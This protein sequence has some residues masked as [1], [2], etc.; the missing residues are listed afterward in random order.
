MT[1][2]VRFAPSPTGHLHVGNAR[3]AVVNWVLARK[4]GG[5]A[6]LRLDDTDAQR[7]TAAFADAILA[8]LAWLGLTWD[9]VERQSERIAMYDAAAEKLRHSGRLYACYETP[10]ELAYARNRQHRMGLPPIYDR[11]ALSLSDEQRATHEADGRTPHWRFRLADQD[12]GFVDLVRG[13]TSF[14][15]RNLSDPVLIRSDG[16]YLYMLPS[17]VDDAD[18]AIT[19]VI[20]GEDHVTNSAI[21]TQLFEALGAP[22][23]M[24]AHL[25]LLTDTVGGKL[26]K[27][28]GSTNLDHFRE[29]GCE[30]MAINAMLATLGTAD[31]IEPFADLDAIVAAFEITRFGRAQPRFDEARLRAINARW[32]RERPYGDVA[33]RFEALGLIGANEPF[34]NAVRGNIERFSDVTL[35]H[36]VCFGEISPQGGDPGFLAVAADLLPDGP[37]SE[38]TWAPWTSAIREA[39][40]TKG[41]ALFKP[42]RRALTGREHGPEL[43]RLLPLMGRERVLG[44]LTGRE[45]GASS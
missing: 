3:I 28:F 44:R 6:V 27:R 12:I 41:K 19:H 36:E 39:T 38:S 23:P 14:H 7:S 45:N 1:L 25:P 9:S 17:V 16:T 8:D 30:P 40:G 26:A 31:D 32:L 29:Q 24:F 13:E 20:R 18:L 2:T 35:W 11:R 21:Q 22:V 43:K 37:L 4:A 15:A 42:L 5:T 34:W 33:E 10:E